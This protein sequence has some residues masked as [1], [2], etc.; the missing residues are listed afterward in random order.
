MDE[1][2]SRPLLPP[3]CWGGVV[4]TSRCGCAREDLTA[5][6]GDAARYSRRSA[7]SSPVLPALP[8]LVRRLRLRVCMGGV[9]GGEAD[10][11]TAL[12]VK[13]WAGRRSSS[14]SE[15]VAKLGEASSL[16]RRRVW[17]K[18][19]SGPVDV[20]KC[21]W[22]RG[23]MG[24]DWASWWLPFQLPCPDDLCAVGETLNRLLGLD[25]AASAAAATAASS[26]EAMYVRLRWPELPLLEFTASE[27]RGALRGELMSVLVGYG[28][29]DALDDESE[30]TSTSNV[31]RLR[32]SSSSTLG[33]MVSRERSSQPC[34][35]LNWARARRLWRCLAICRMGKRRR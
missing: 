12:V 22:R 4:G 18:D 14:S 25:A 23:L 29:S 13:E 33:S 31:M 1:G 2:R 8:S 10:R 28:K 34:L 3:F 24:D 19:T 17:K 7:P 27:K 35:A 5:G 30:C 16:V 9:R 32:R 26:N 6:E 15:G 20:V 11:T 21:C